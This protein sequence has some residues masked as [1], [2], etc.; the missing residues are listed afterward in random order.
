VIF[1]H[2][3]SR[4][5]AAVEI[6]VSAGRTLAQIAADRGIKI[7]TVRAHTKIVFS[8]THTRGQAELTGVLTRLAF[9][10]PRAENANAASNAAGPALAI[11]NREAA[12]A[13][14]NLYRDEGES[15]AASRRSSGQKSSPLRQTRWL[16]RRTGSA[17]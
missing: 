10:V 3:R 2:G 17:T 12:A 8:K 6:A 7:G 9:V 1:R 13:R 16:H 15:E 4:R 11:K 14:A 5:K